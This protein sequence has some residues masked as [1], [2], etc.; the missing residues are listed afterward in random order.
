M[1]SLIPKIEKCLGKKE[2]RRLRGVLEVFFKVKDSRAKSIKVIQNT[3]RS[4]SLRKCVVNIL[5]GE[6]DLPATPPP[7]DVGVKYPFIFN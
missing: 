5:Y 1:I 3:T 2:M 6:R 4:K 7:N